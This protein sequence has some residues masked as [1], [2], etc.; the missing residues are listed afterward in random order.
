M[1]FLKSGPNQAAYEKYY[2]VQSLKSQ[3]QRAYLVGE[4][5]KIRKTIEKPRYLNINIEVE[6][7]RNEIKYSGTVLN[8]KKKTI[9]ELVMTRYE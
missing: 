7:H 2:A 5:K 1:W 3:M 8:R 9:T 6:K 4:T